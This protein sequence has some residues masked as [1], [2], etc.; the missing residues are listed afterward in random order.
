MLTDIPVP[1]PDLMSELLLDMRFRG[2]Q[3]RRIEMTPPFGLGFGSEPGRAHFHFVAAGRVVL[4]DAAGEVHAVSPGTAILLPHGG[5]HQVLSAE[6]LSAR[7]IGS[8]PAVPVC[9]G[10]S[11][12]SACGGDPGCPAN[13]ILFSSCMQFELGGMQGLVRLMPP[14]MLVGTLADRHPEILAILRAMESEV[15]GR[16][17]GGG[18]AP[19]P[20]PPPAGG[21]HQD[22]AGGGGGGAAPPPPP[23]PPTPPRGGRPRRGPRAPRPG[24]PPRDGR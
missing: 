18:P 22:P 13:A 7:D 1:P 8:F 24:P 2:V 17:G 20:R 15:C 21:P 12:I 11:D 16:R 23:T 14:V 6:G 3:Y 4:R 10:L 19:R 5:T 9:D